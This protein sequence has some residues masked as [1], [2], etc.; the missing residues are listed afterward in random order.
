M[1][2]Y[3]F[4]VFILI[5]T[6]QANAQDW[7]V[8]GYYATNSFNSEVANGQ[9]IKD[10]ADEFGFMVD[11]MT[12]TLMMYSAGIGLLKYDDR[13]GFTQTIQVVGGIGDGDIRN[14]DSDASALNVF[15]EA[16]PRWF[17]GENNSSYFAL[18]AGFNT[19]VESER[20]I[21][22]CEDCYSEDIDIDGGLY[23][24]GVIS[25][26]FSVLSVGLHYLQYADDDE[27]MENSLRLV[28]GT[29][30]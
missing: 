30:F 17:F 16:G 6:S 12:P 19:L 5:F 4:F 26:S 27:G 20:S 2:K 7:V 21:S 1:K 15:A 23:F 28:V 22:F 3:F 14:E 10:D 25:H 29:N 24:A 11:Y 9:N 8:N 18:K 13:A